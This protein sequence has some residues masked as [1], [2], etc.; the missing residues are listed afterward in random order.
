MTATNKKVA[1]VCDWLIGGGAEKVVLELHKLF[2]EAPIYTSYC[3]PGWR[4]KLDNK[5][6]SGWLQYWPFSHL[7]KFIPFLRIWWFQ[8]LKFNGYDLVISASGAEAKGIKVPENTKHISYI[9][10]PTHYYWSKYDDY[11]KNP[12]FGIFNPLA[13]FGLKLLIKPLRKCDF[14]AAQRP[15]K[16]IANSTHT[17]NQ[18][19]KYYNRE[20]EVIHPPVDVAR[21]KDFSSKTRNGFVVVGRQVPY[22]RI[23]LAVMACTRL[24]LP[25]TIIGDGPEHQKLEKIAGPTCTFITNAK[26]Q[27]IATILGKSKAFLFT[28]LEDFGIAPVEAMAAG[29][30][31][32]A[33]KAGGALDYVIDGKTGIFFEKQ[34][35]AA[36]IGAIKKFNEIGFE[37]TSCINKAQEFSVKIFIKKIIQAQLNR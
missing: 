36:L 33:Y 9:H 27:E 10:A 7:R 22:K 4:K 11:I 25:L 24:N 16:L 35:A 21:F 3:T 8:S 15:N 18:I 2:P 26:D 20:A 14:N 23:D 30:P 31:V 6:V 29:T 32:I 37:S 34:T 19:K 5:V 28:G 12:G 13:R 17:K 1:I